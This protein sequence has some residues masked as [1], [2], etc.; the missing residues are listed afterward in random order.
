MDVVERD[1]LVVPRP[2]AAET[3]TML[4]Q[5]REEPFSLVECVF[6][7]QGEGA[8]MLRDMSIGCAALRTTRTQALCQTHEIGRSPLG[9]RGSLCRCG[10]S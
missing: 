4:E 6:G 10:G 2:L 7:C 3:L 1:G 9:G 8:V 5:L